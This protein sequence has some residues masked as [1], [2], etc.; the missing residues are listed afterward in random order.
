MDPKKGYRVGTEPKE[1]VPSPK[2]TIPAAESV[3][4]RKFRRIGKVVHQRFSR[5]TGAM[6]M[7]IGILVGEQRR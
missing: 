6:G 4:F 5:Q 1:I 2:K 7:E 3:G